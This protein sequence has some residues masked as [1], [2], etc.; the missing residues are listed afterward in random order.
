[1]SSFRFTW[2]YALMH[3]IIRWSRE[4]VDTIT[5]KTTPYTHRIPP[6]AGTGHFDFFCFSFFAWSRAGFQAQNP[7]P[8]LKL[9]RGAGI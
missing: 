5:A 8:S 3:T 6:R 4:I 9:A 1:M 2:G 7:A